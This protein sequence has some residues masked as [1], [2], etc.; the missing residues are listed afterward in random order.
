MSSS[1]DNEPILIDGPL[2]ARIAALKER[3]SSVQAAKEA[4][5]KMRYVCSCVSAAAYSLVRM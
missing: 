4:L 5:R 2:R 3:L 1:L